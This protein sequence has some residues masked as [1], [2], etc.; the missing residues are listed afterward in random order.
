VRRS[1]ALV[2]LIAMACTGGGSPAPTL[3][4]TPSPKAELHRGGQAI[5]GAEQ[6]PEC[7]NPITSCAGYKWTFMT[8]LQHVLPRAMEVSPDSLFVASPLLRE[9]P[10]LENGGVSQSPFTVT[11]RIRDGAV[12]D[13]GSPITS[14]DFA[15]TWRA[16]MHTTGS[17]W[18]RR[19]EHVAGINS[20]D[21]ATA[22]LKFSEPYAPWPELFGGSFGFVLKASAFPE[23]AADPEPDLRN[24]LIDRIPFSGGPF[25]LESWSRDRALLVRN[26][27]YF[28][29][30]ALLDRVT[31]VP[32]S[33][34][35]PADLQRLLSGELEAMSPSFEIGR[36]L[37][38]VYGLVGVGG[39]G[40][41][42]VD[43][44]A[45]WF[46]VDS[47]PLDDPGVRLALAHAI[48]RQAIVDALL[49]PTDSSAAV[50]NCGLLALPGV[51]PWCATQP[52][53]RFDYDPAESRRILGLA[54]YDCSKQFCTKEGTRLTIEIAA[55]EAAVFQQE[56]LDLLVAQARKAGIDLR[57][58]VR[59]GLPL[60]VR[61]P[62]PFARVSITVCSRTVPVDP[63]VTD[64]FSLCA[65]T[66]DLFR[67]EIAWC[68]QAAASYARDADR[69]IDIDAR[70]ELM[71]KVYDQEAGEVIGLPLFVV[72]VLSLWRTDQIRGPISGY[73]STVYGM[74]FNMNDWYEV[75]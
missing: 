45:L 68:N 44:E 24:L 59:A 67:D 1:A 11:F 60:G 16:L 2:L 54:G 55:D 31:F 70:R 35:V 37:D 5:F 65:P 64:L 28:G 21:P 18:T 38:Q 57:R 43:A 71:E 53:A 46:N 69:Q 32:A 25:T 40:G 61:L 8:V 29:S 42:G 62:C 17:I 72:P 50:F 14:T 63:S 19:Y 10:T 41:P 56:V 7:L 47:P 52:F 75:S 49:S 23:L 51:G 34:D 73:S 20:P 6:W 9:A 13:D 39:K 66:A 58:Y 48:D 36:E 3:S 27:R 4:R 30:R 22:V 74:F 33:G 12:W 26:D 15:F